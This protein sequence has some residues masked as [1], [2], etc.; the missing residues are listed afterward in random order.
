MD[1]LRNDSI[2]HQMRYSDILQ[3]IPNSSSPNTFQIAIAALL[4]PKNDFFEANGM[5]VGIDRTFLDSRPSTEEESE[6]AS[7]E[8]SRKKKVHTLSTIQPIQSAQ[9]SF[10]G[11][12]VS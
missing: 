4:G 9:D 10:T 11:I 6:E 1:E 7:S 3:T 12:S 2:F 8:S 5:A